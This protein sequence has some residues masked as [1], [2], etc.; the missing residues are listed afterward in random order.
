MTQTL[1]SRKPV[2]A[3]VGRPNV[4]KSTLVNRLVGHRSAIVDDQPG[5]T[6][7]RAYFEVE[8]LKFPFTLIDT[9]G[10]DY[11]TKPG[12]DLLV[13]KTKVNEQVLLALEEADVV[14]F[15]VDGQTGIVDEDERLVKQLRQLHKP[16]YLVVNKSDNTAQRHNASEFYKLG[17]GDPYPISALHG[18][19]GVG[20]LLDTLLKTFGDLGF[21]KQAEDFDNQPIRLAMI[22]RP[23]VGKSSLV[24]ALLGTERHIV[25]EISGTTRDAIDSPFEWQGQP[26]VLVDT[27]GI[28]RKSK[29]DYGVELF[30]VDRAWQALKRADITVL[31]ID[32]A[33]GLTDQDKHLIQESNEKGN[34]LMIAVNKWDLIEKKTADSL[35][36]Y[37]EKLY[38]QVPHAAF[39]PIIFISAKTGQRV[40]QI[41]TTALTISANHRRRIQTSLINQ[42]ILEAMDLSPPP[43]VKGKRFKVYYATQV[44][45]APPVFVLFC[46]QK[47]LI[48]EPYR[49][50][51]ENRLRENIH[52]EG[53]PIVIACRPKLVAGPQSRGKGIPRKLT[54][55]SSV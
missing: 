40:D 2:V 47:S 28:R 49:R 38:G 19:T 53:T 21:S 42:I 35:K 10:F 41:L 8:W 52:F 46:N 4:G 55:T 34:A 45:S 50:Y 39:A 26:F 36:I 13:I 16:I 5:V 23:N 37:K 3:L 17:L 6:R 20:D 51:L 15:M 18:T 30:S 33:E 24:N 27:A 54:Q 48:T 14:L 9:G 44:S 11:D 43:S 32:A 22:G 25:S 29:V 31:V 12:S 7:D 1:N